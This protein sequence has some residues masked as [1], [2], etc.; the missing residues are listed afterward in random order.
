MDKYIIGITGAS[1]SVYAHRLMQALKKFGG[2]IRLDVVASETALEVWKHEMPG[3]VFPG[4]ECNVYSNQDYFAP[5]ASGSALY[6][7][8]IV[9]PCSMGTLA[10][11]AHGTSDN[12]LCRAADVMIKEKRKLLLV[13][14]EAPYS[15]IHLRNMTS[16][17]EAGAIICPASPSFYNLPADLEELEMTVVNKILDQLGIEHPG[18]RWGV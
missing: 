18:R 14:R 13:P 8:M 15:L 9:V 17:A 4:T 5:M 10:R 16:L 3:Q 1:G 7:A 12:L 2:K 6:L 11:I